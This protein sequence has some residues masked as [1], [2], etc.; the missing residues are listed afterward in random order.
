M[1]KVNDFLMKIECVIGVI[2]LISLFIVIT[3]NMFSRYLFNAPIFWADELAAFL[4]VWTTFL[5]CSY[6]MGLDGHIRIKVLEDHFPQKVTLTLHVL[7]NLIVMGMFIYL[8]GPTLSTF[9]TLGK[10]M[11]LRFLLR[12]VYTILPLAFSLMAFHCINNVVVDIK[13]LRACNC[14]AS[15]SA[16]KD[17]E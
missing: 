9:P 6:I 7:F 4:Y 1:K 12:Y 2:L 13:A 14:T 5:S 11:A 15:N 16:Q 17:D 8:L 10:A 3:V